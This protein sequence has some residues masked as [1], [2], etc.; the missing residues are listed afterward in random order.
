VVRPDSEYHVAAS[1]SGVSTPSTI[2]VELAGTL[3]TGRTFNVSRIASVEPYATKIL[4]LDVRTYAPT[5]A[6]ETVFIHD[7]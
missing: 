6:A 4:Q 5:R 7:C 2:Y 3:D 1:I